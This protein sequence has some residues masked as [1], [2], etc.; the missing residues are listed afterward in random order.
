[1][2]RYA[3]ICILV[4]LGLSSSVQA[5]EVRY[6]ATGVYETDDL[7][8]ALSQ[9]P[10]AGWLVL[11]SDGTY[12]LD[13]QVADHGRYQ[14]MPAGGQLARDT[15]F[16]ISSMGYQFLAYPQDDLLAVWLPLTANGTNYWVT[17]Q[18][19]A[20][21]GTGPANASTAAAAQPETAAFAGVV[22]YGTTSAPTYY[23]Y[24]PATGHFYE[25][26]K[27]LILRPDGT[28]YLKAD[29]GST[30]TVEEGTY[31]IAGNQVLLTFSDGSVLALTVEEQGRKLNW[32][33]DGILLSEF[34]YLGET[35]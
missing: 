34:F 15:I 32:Y 11:E 17:L 18:R 20:P 23:H 35:K 31:R 29:F 28:F 2:M 25:D 3:V 30:T 19:A 33:S 9:G 1:M 27:G 8:Q 5:Q 26:Q 13:F 12:S 24:N 22:M 16:F 14:Y 7:G 10:F 21:L 6:Q 4:G